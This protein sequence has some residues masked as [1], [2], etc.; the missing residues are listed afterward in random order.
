MER[1]ADRWDRLWGS[2]SPS[3]ALV[4]GRAH[5]GGDDGPKQTVVG[6][7]DGETKIGDTHGGEE[8]RLNLKVVSKTELLQQ[9]ISPYR[10]L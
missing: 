5:P 6:E 3:A 8:I 2:G 9:G 7:T 1:R 4:E 10:K